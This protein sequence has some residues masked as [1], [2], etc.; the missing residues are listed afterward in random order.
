M[1]D[2]ESEAMARYTG[3]V[4]QCPP[5]EKPKRGKWKVWSKTVKER[6]SDPRADAGWLEPPPDVKEERRQRRIAGARRERIARRNA[7]IMRKR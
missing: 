6:S 5:G 2:D 7:E 4:T 1:S 3:E